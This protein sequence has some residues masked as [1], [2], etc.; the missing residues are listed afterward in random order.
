[1]PG[2]ADY[3]HKN[4][5]LLMNMLQAHKDPGA[6]TSQSHAHPELSHMP[7]RQR[8]LHFLGRLC[9]PFH[10]RHPAVWGQGADVHWVLILGTVPAV[11][12]ANWRLDGASVNCLVME[13]KSRTNNADSKRGKVRVHGNVSSPKV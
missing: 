10:H 2:A 6:P 12:D 13:Q 9:V 8:D 7:K 3:A 5:E 1:M 11:R 4:P